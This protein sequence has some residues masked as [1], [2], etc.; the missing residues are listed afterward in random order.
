MPKEPILLAVPVPQDLREALAA[1]Y[2]LV[3]QD[4]ASGP[5]PGFRIAVT[6]AKD[7]ADAALMDRLPELR[8]I[9]SMGAGLDRI[10]L[11]AARHRGIAV[12]H[13]PDEL[14]DDVADFAIALMFAAARR[15][16]TA[17]RFV[18][19]GR[20][21]AGE[22][23]APAIGLRG[24]TVGVVGLGRIGQQIARQASGLGMTVAWTGPRPKPELPWRH[25]PSV[26]ELASRSDVLIL[27]SPGGPATRHLVDAAVLNALGPRGILVNVARGSVVDEAALFAALEERRIAGAGLDVFEGEPGIDPRFLAR[28]DVVL[29]PHYASIT[30][31]T[32]A[33]II[34]R[35]ISDIAAFRAGDRFYDAAAA[36]G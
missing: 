32:R 21:A 17:D 19:A 8:L 7:G 34:A 12:A 5:H 29:A 10:D 20:W 9:A 35:M 14:T 23:M 4:A 25:I 1:E 13:T 16:A 27:A 30:E 33:A 26:L 22:R 18:R 15:V 3:A 11:A 31:E 6:M 28:D 2:T 36:L 24:K